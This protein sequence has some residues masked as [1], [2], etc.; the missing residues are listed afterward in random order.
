MRGGGS[1][2][3]QPEV[4]GAW[5][6]ESPHPPTP[7]DLAWKKEP[8]DGAHSL[9]SLSWQSANRNGPLPHLWGSY[10]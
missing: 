7:P 4:V 6:P 8:A 10:T 3:W 9:L 2:K 1:W 5:L